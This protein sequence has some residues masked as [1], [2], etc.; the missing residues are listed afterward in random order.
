MWPF[1]GISTRNA[2]L[3]AQSGKVAGFQVLQWF[4]VEFL[5]NIR[6]SRLRFA[7]NGGDKTGGES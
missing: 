6:I 3:L 5:S 2:N 1:L 7:Y 4:Q